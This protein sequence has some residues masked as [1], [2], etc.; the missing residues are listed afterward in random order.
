MQSW[1]RGQEGL[2][3]QGGQIAYS[4]IT[5][6]VDSVAVSK[7]QTEFRIVILSVSR[8]LKIARVPLIGP[9]GDQERDFWASGCSR[10][11]GLSHHVLVQGQG[12][13]R[14]AHLP[15]LRS[16]IHFSQERTCSPQCRANRDSSS[17]L[18]TNSQA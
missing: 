8:C 17:D 6:T 1:Q 10:Y 2:V 4:H 3:L 12:H 11:D 13:P 18:Q 5:E 7:N 16:G 14:T 15:S 9:Q